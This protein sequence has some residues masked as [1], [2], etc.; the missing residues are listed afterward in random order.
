M[1][2]HITHDP[3][4]NTVDRDDFLALLDIE[5]YNDRTDAFDEIIRLAGV[6]GDRQ[7]V[8]MWEYRLASF[9]RLEDAG[10]ERAYSG[11]WEQSPIAYESWE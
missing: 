9:I 4:Y 10:D 1:A 2:D 5:R 7:A 11:D 6:D 3:I 8:A